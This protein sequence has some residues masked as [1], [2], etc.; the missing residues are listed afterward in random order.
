[1][2]R[3]PHWSLV[4]FTLLAFVLLMPGRAF[5]GPPPIDPKNM[6]GQF[7][8][9]ASVPIG[10]LT[11]RVLGVGGFEEPKVG[12]A[13]NLE[14]VDMRGVVETRTAVTDESG[15]A[16]FA[17]LESFI[18]GEAIA[19]VDFDSGRIRSVSMPL[20]SDAGL[21]VMLVEG[22]SREGSQVNVAFSR[23]DVPV[24]QVMVGIFNL[25]RE[26]GMPGEKVRLTVTPPE[27]DPVIR[28]AVTDNQGRV[29]FGDLEAFPAE[30]RFVAAA[31]INDVIR[32]QS[33]PFSLSSENGM[34]LALAIAPEQIRELQIDGSLK[35]GQV[36]VRVLDPSDQP[37][38]GQTVQVMQ[39][40]AA[41]I[42][43]P[44]EGTTDEKGVATV[45]VPVRA[46]A[47]YSVVVPYE[48]APFRSS[49]FF[50]DR[51]GGIR[52]TLR[53][54]PVSNDYSLVRSGMYVDMEAEENDSAQVRQRLELVVGDR[55]HAVA[56]WD[57]NFR[58][59]APEGARG[60]GVFDESETWLEHSEMAPYATLARPIPP[61]TVVH[62]DFGYFLDHD[63]TIDFDWQPPFEALDV[64]VVVREGL[65]FDGDGKVVSDKNAE[66]MTIYSIG[67]VKPNEH[68]SFTM[69]GLPVGVRI[70]RQLG[71]GF[72]IL[73]GVVLIIG[74]AVRP[75]TNTRVRL[76]QRKQELITVLEGNP[77]E[78][79]RERALTALDRVYRQLRALDSVEEATHKPS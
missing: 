22:A 50:A 29:I 63:G 75:A 40:T 13:V 18:G 45:D 19:S 17:E 60:M 77:S 9:D 68:V 59:Q 36:V 42:E 20:S 30:S 4:V 7:R 79:V 31:L 32:Q 5:A 2:N 25:A 3:R 49:R 14:V 23:D 26:T 35:P 27:G 46:D 15:R 28:T 74:L 47:L 78:R 51:R 56:F 1:M 44:F 37:V 52:V 66:N 70:F 48:E 24:G 62:F 16:T 61:D 76:E 73:F 38:T 55:E 10:S 58:L 33:E 54:Y 69:S 71:F 8:P 53:V 39:I 12:Q 41:Q 67:G 6:S 21:R 64:R 65:V 11:V 43:T 34:A 72:G 57:P